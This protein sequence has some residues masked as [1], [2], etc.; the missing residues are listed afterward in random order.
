MLV[1]YAPENGA[2]EEY[3][4]RPNTIRVSESEMIE[5]RAGCSFE[6]WVGRVISG[7]AGARRVLLWHCIRRTHPALRFE[8]T[9]DFAWS[10]LTIERE[11]DELLKIRA[12]VEANRTL[13]DEDK[14]EAL[15]SID[16][17]IEERRRIEPVDPTIPA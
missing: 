2:R 16:A 6:E 10:E 5:K 14:A 4:F 11:L 3:P 12:A 1:I 9:P 17:D 13:S 8:D 15:D 7:H